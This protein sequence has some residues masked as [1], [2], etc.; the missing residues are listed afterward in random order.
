MLADEAPYAD[1]KGHHDRSHHVD[2]IPP[3]SAV[4]VERGAPAARADRRRLAPGDVDDRS[5]PFLVDG[6]EDVQVWPVQPQHD[7]V[8]HESGSARLGVL[9][10]NLGSRAHLSGGP[11]AQGSYQDSL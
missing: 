3:A 11:S 4:G 8:R 5:A 10:Y 7:T 2:H 9:A 1:R 6:L